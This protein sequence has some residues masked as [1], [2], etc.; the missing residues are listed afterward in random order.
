MITTRRAIRNFRDQP[1]PRELL[2]KVVEAI[3][4]APPSFTP[5]KTE[6][7]VVQ[8]TAVIR[9]ALPE[10]IRIYDGLLKAMSHPVARLFVRR[11]VGSAKCKM[12]ETHVIPLM[13]SRLPELKRG[14]EDTI[15]RD[16]PAMILFY[17]QR[18]AE[19]PNAD[20]HIALTYGLL[21]PHAIGLGGTI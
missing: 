18:D 19:N 12:L 15:T 9:R 1:V 11:K 2:E 3:S 10:M 20:I 13:N 16:A 14:V 17:A 4:F 8:D 6:I 5:V 21:V 7:V